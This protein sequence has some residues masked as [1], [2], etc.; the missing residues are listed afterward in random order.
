[1]MKSYQVLEGLAMH[2]IE[3]SEAGLSDFAIVEL[4]LH[5]GPQP[6]NEI[7]RRV[8]A[9]KKAAQVSHC[10]R[11][12]ASRRSRNSSR[13]APVTSVRPHARAIEV[14]VSAPD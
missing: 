7:G 8:A 3:A 12:F 11:L 6:V 14:E 4:L 1:M 2:S 9:M 13:S 5:R 10:T